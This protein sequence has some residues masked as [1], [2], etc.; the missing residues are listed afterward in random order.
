MPYRAPYRGPDMDITRA[1]NRNALQV[2]REPYWHKLA[3][4]C[5][6]GYRSGPKTYIARWTNDTGYHYKSVGACEYDVAKQQAE[7]WFAQCKTGVIAHGTVTDACKQYVNNQRNLKGHGPADKSDGMFAKHVYKAQIGAKLLDALRTVDIEAWR[8]GLVTPE[9][10][11]RAA[12]RIL[13]S[14]KAALN[15]GFQRGMAPSDAVWRRVKALQG[16]GA[17]DRSRTAYLTPQQRGLLLGACTPGLANL[18]RGHLYTAARPGEL[19]AATVKDF[20]PVHKRLKLTT[21]KGK[22]GERSREVP[23][24]PAAVSFF[25][26]MSRSKL[27]NA[28]LMGEWK[29]YI[30][31]AEMR[32]AVKK[33]GGRVPHDTS[34]YTMRHC[35]I[36]DMLKAGLDVGAV[37]KITGT[38][39]TM[40]SD[41][42]YKFIH[43][44]VADKLASIVSF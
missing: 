44:D 27:P 3:K 24:A 4:H 7:V 9:R 11:K 18:L 40:I 10:S 30:V 20:D 8:D 31:T 33:L 21:G 38:S 42:Y 23:L 34:R 35:A 39:I 19:L 41:H 12:N 15:F 16:D 43:T 1:K 5:Y 2:R 28:K 14:F 29:E 17:K 36:S 32:A 6:L 25:V 13:R 22:N 37:A 26:E